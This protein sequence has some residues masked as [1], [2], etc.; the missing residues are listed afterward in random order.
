QQP[1]LLAGNPGDGSTCSC[2]GCRVND[3]R[4][5]GWYLDVP[6]KN[7][8]TGDHTDSGFHAD[9][10]S[11]CLVDFG[12]RIL[13]SGYGTMCCGS[14]YILH[15]YYRKAHKSCYLAGGRGTNCGIQCIWFNERSE[16]GESANPPCHANNYGGY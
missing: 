5:T 12:C 3:H 14:H 8:A 6:E 16:A 7:C 13:P 15:T 10:A 1:W 4:N 11:I 9:D 2:L